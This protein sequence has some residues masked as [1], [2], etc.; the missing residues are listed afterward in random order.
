MSYAQR[1]IIAELVAATF[2]YSY[3]GWTLVT[4]AQSGAYAE[5]GGL[6]AWAQS[7]LWL[8]LATIV[9]SI[10]IAIVFSIVWHLVTGEDI[11][12]LTDERD[13]VISGFGW[14]INGIVISLAFVGAIAMLAYGLSGVV[15]LS[16]ILI[17]FMLGDVASSIGKL[18]RYQMGG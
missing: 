12:D 11:D 17:G 1:A 9:I 16:T 3:I 5:P 14:K 18:I 2:L 6:Q 4:G 8:M 10:V 7:V 13:A 15:A